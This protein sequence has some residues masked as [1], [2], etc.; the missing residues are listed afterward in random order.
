MFWLLFFSFFIM[1][2]RDTLS[3]RKRGESVSLVQ[4]FRHNFKKLKD[5]IDQRFFKKK[6]LKIVENCKIGVRPRNHN[7]SYWT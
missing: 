3:A 4:S 7:L 6:K 2:V 5:Q 1:S